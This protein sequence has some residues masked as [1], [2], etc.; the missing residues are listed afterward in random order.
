MYMPAIDRSLSD[1]RYLDSI[2]C[3]PDIQR[4]L[5]D[6]AK[7]FFDVD[8]T[9]KAVIKTTKDA[10]NA[11]KSFTADGLFTTFENACQILDKVQVRAAV[12]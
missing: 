8:R 7:M 1:C 2:F 12:Y 3:A 6:E 11:Y 5:P 4:Q 9:W 10:A